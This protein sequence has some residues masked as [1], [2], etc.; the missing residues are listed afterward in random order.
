LEPLLAAIRF[1]SLLY[2]VDHG[3]ILHI[4]NIGVE[5]VRL[6]VDHIDIVVDLLLKLRK[7]VGRTEP[8]VLHKELVVIAH[9]VDPAVV[10]AAVTPMRVSKDG[11]V[12]AARARELVPGREAELGIVVA[13][14]VAEVVAMLPRMREEVVDHQTRIDKHAGRVI[15]I[16]LRV[17]RLIE[18]HRSENQASIHHR[19]IPKAVHEDAARGRINIVGG[20][21]KEVGL[22]RSPISGPP[23]V[24]RFLIEPAAGNPEVVLGR[25]RHIGS[26]LQ[27]L[28]WRRQV[29]DRF[30]LKRR[31]ETADVLKAPFSLGPVARHPAS[32]IGRYAPH[33]ADPYKVL[34][35]QVPL[36]ITADPDGVGILGTSLGR[37]FVNRRRR[38]DLDHQG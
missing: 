36:P 24:A 25:S 30:R 1:Q 14:E 28:R 32:S 7:V 18:V 17:H 4:R 10:V 37:N 15:E 2:R 12:P 26:C 5:D 13:I 35:I 33:A 29:G 8:F 19:V 11:V 22:H 27:G 23:L 38:F 16:G 20:R 34:P 31:P 9:P 6:V 3:H 21:P